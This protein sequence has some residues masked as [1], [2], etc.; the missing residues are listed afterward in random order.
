MIYFV[1]LMCLAE[2]E[3]FE[4]SGEEGGRTAGRVSREADTISVRQEDDEQEHETGLAIKDVRV[5]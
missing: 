2:K 3:R 1:L 5:L 4:P